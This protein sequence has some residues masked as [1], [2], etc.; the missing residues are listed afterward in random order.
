MYLLWLVIFW[1]MQAGAQVLFKLGSDIPGRY[2]LFYALG[3]VPGASSI[4]ILMQLYKVMNPNLALGLGTGG[5]FL[6]A[7]IAMAV[8]FRSSLSLQQ[9]GAMLLI[10]VG[11][12]LFTVTRGGT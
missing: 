4:L 7:Q 5:G 11:M 6:C 2:W 3:N 12:A 8:L 10:A 1:L 9:Y